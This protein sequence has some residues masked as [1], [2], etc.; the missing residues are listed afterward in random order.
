MKDPKRLERYQRWKAV[1]D[2]TQGVSV[3]AELWKMCGQDQ[4]SV[5]Q[6]IVDGKVDPYYTLLKEGRRSIWIDIQANLTEPPEIP[7]G[8]ESTY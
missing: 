5:V 7:E 3:L 8:N 4:T 1:F 6:S 2:T